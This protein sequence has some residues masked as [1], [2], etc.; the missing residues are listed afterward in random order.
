MKYFIHAM[1]KNLFLLFNTQK[2]T[3]LTHFCDLKI[4]GLRRSQS[5]DF[6][7]LDCNSYL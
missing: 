7:S 1:A 6:G 2:S 4:L 5:W 3:I